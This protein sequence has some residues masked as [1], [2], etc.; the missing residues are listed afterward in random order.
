MENFSLALMA[1][2]IIQMK[3]NNLT[4]DIK[5]LI[6][7]ANSQRRKASTANSQS[8]QLWWYQNSKENKVVCLIGLGSQTFPIIL[9]IAL[10]LANSKISTPTVDNISDCATKTEIE[11]L[12]YPPQN[13]AT[14]LGS[15]AV[16]TILHIGMGYH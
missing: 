5:T 11:G 10:A 14:F 15:S 3:V 1:R 16:A 2:T 6:F 13:V 8:P 4:E 12:V 9:N 7:T